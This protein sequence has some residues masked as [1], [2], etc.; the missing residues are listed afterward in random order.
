MKKTLSALAIAAALMCGSCY[1]PNKTWN[2]LHDWNGKVTDSKW[3]NEAVFL[4]LNIIP[5]Y[6]V[7]YLADILIFNSIE[8][9]KGEGK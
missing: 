5:V 4:G 7:C 8:F 3:G 2:N 6:G 1:G 9:W